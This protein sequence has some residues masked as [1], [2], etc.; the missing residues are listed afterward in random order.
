MP[1]AKKEAT[2]AEVREKLRR[3]QAV[4]LGDYRGLDV[5]SLTELRRELGR[6]AVEL[7]VVKNTLT[8]RAARELGLEGLDPYLEG[9]TVLAFGYEDPVVAAKIVSTFARSHK[10]MEI[11]GGLLGTRVIDAEGVRALADLPSRE[12]LLARVLGAIQG[13]LQGMVNVLQGP[14]RGFA[15][16][17]DALRRQRAGEA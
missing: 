2:V 6:S 5:K 4:V 12:V 16:G 7:K 3:S 1:T 9:P 15:T 14:L 11:K 17:L 8:K 10:E 13:P